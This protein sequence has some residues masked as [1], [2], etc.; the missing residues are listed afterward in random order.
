M[1]TF[2]LELQKACHTS[3]SEIRCEDDI[4][5]TRR[6]LRDKLDSTRKRT[7]REPIEPVYK[8]NLDVRTCNPCPPIPRESVSSASDTINC[9]FEDDGK[10]SDYDQS[11]SENVKRQINVDEALRPKRKVQFETKCREFTPTCGGTDS[12]NF[13]V[14]LIKLE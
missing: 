5:E 8:P 10:E 14:S 11:A 4:P 12:V 13:Q 2:Q 7:N 3:P 1:T 9:R 6:K